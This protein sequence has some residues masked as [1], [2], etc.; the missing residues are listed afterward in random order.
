M[1]IDFDA[2]FGPGGAR[3]AQHEFQSRQSPLPG[4]AQRKCPPL[5]LELVLPGGCAVCRLRLSF[6]EPVTGN[7]FCDSVAVYRCSACGR[8]YRLIR[9][10]GEWTHPTAEGALLP[11]PPSF[12]S[13]RP[14]PGW[15]VDIPAPAWIE[16]LIRDFE[17][18]II[19]AGRQIT[20]APEKDCGF[21]VAIFWQP[22]DGP[23]HWSCPAC[24]WRSVAVL[25]SG[26]LVDCLGSPLPQPTAEAN[27][28]RSAEAGLANHSVPAEELEL[29][30]RLRQWAEANGWPEVAVSRGVKVLAGE[31]NWQ[32]FLAYLSTRQPTFTADRSRR[33]KLF[34]LA[35][36]YLD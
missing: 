29:V 21:P 32:R 24:G 10:F 18:V 14:L 33:S 35:E 1:P 3:T 28:S 19:R 7:L 15:P 36:R 13:G 25:D 20:H 17:K 26:R 16:D 5:L 8:C 31:G 9:E 22:P 6:V 12:P 27:E 11:G 23:P 4:A 2:L 34:S 30:N